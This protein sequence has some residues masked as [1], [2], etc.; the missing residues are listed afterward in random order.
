MIQPLVRWMRLVVPRGEVLSVAVAGVVVIDTIYGI[1]LLRNWAPD[2]GIVANFRLSFLVVCS[3]VYGVLRA[4]MF[5][6]ALDV[7]YRRWLELTPWRPGR[8]MPAGPLLLVPQDLMVMAI[9]VALYHE[10]TPSLLML[11]VAFLS[12]YLVTMAAINRLI[13]EWAL[14][15]TAAFALAAAPMLYPHWEYILALEIACYVPTAW[16]IRRGMRSFPWKLPDLLESRSFKTAAEAIKDRRLGWPYDV[17]QFNPPELKVPRSDGICLSFLAGWLELS[18]LLSLN[19][20]QRIPLLVVVGKGLVFSPFFIVAYYLENHRSPNSFWGR[21]LTLRWIIP[22]FDRVWIIPVGAGA[23]AA[24]GHV[25][26]PLYWNALAL[27]G[28][29][30]VVLVLGPHADRWRLTGEH[31]LAFGWNPAATAAKDFIE[32]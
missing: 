25:F 19:D 11:P 27:T 28:F 30:L 22:R 14:A 29:L 32:I 1:A 2:A 18:L 15:Y 4:G 3:L 17:L 26:L 10:V 6:P 7:D 5:H 13:G 12:G 23:L 24:T 16:A 8:L 20:I 31:R 21:L 9:F